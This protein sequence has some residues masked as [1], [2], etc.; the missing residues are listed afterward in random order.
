[1]QPSKFSIQIFQNHTLKKLNII[2]KWSVPKCRFTFQIAIILAKMLA[3]ENCSWGPPT[4]E[5]LE[6]VCQ[7]KMF[8]RK[9]LQAA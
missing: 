2:P 5:V 7:I 8:T 1:V 9:F 6:N 3:K 4:I